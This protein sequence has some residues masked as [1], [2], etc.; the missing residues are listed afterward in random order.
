MTGFSYRRG[1]AG[2][3]DEEEDLHLSPCPA[4][5]VYRSVLKVYDKEVNVKDKDGR[6][7]YI[8]DG[9]EVGGGNLRHLLFSSLSSGLW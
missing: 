2:Q 8:G 3:V 6:R 4:F 9:S 1:K 7:G 5:K